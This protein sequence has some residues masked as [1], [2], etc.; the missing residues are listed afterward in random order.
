MP[1][2]IIRSYSAELDHVD[3]SKR[4]IGCRL[5][6]SAIDRYRSVISPE[7]GDWTE[8]LKNPVVMHEHGLCPSRGTLAVGNCTMMRAY[9]GPR[10]PEIRAITRFHKDDPFA[11]LLFQKYSRNE[12]RAWSIHAQ[13]VHGT[14]G[15]PTR[16][17]LRSRPEL[18][19][20]DVIYRAW[21]VL[22]YSTVGIGGLSEALTMTVDE[23]RSVLALEADG[24]WIP[25]AVLSQARSMLAAV[26]VTEP[27]ADPELPAL[28]G[29]TY[30]QR[31]AALL[32]Q[33]KTELDPQ[34]LQK[35]L[36]M[37]ADFRRGIV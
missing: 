25:P 3:E 37:R 23:S 29:R 15:R 26:P 32:Q 31:S 21:S 14:A 34:R 27:E 35:E 1:D 16:D 20:C 12:M 4:T 30:E 22:E 36:D 10:G 2:Q 33:I 11:E 9:K 7:G 6:T 5:N 18:K 24:I 17:E 28:T 19:D 13:P 8:Y